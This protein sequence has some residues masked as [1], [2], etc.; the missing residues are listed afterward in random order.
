MSLNE[1]PA[2]DP[3][4]R[5]FWAGYLA[6]V[7]PGATARFYEAFYFADSEQVA[8]ELGQ[9]VLAGRKRA[10]AAL[11]WGLQAQ[12]KRPPV[13]GDLSI[14]TTWAGEPLCIIETRAT[15]LRRYDEVDAAFAA[16][17]GEGDGS[18][19]YWRAEH[20]AYFSRECA[21][22]GRQPTPEMPV[23]CEHFAVVHPPPFADPSDGAC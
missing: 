7:G 19:A 11:V 4:L 8:D 12:A 20:W 17:E 18:L 15:T 22:I 14:V 5:A 6:R 3:R 1:L 16:A 23:L 2:S 21:R 9:L 13:V 10:T